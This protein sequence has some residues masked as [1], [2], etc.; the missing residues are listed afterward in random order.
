[1]SISFLERFKGKTSKH[2]RAK[3]FNDIILKKIIKTNILQCKKTI[4][5]YI[6]KFLKVCKDVLSEC[7]ILFDT[8]LEEYKEDINIQDEK[9][10]IYLAKNYLISKKI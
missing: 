9:G 6:G 4:K 2:I 3:I 8:V 5:D 1:M 7:I 10:K